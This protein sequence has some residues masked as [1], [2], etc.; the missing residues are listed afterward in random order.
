LRRF[1]AEFVGLPEDHP[2]VARACI[3]IMAPF[4]MLILSDSR[5]IKR[6]L[7]SLGLGADDAADMAR[8]LV[9]FAIGGLEAIGRDA[10]R[11]HS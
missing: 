2:S 1:V 10:R 4:C 3:S 6:A 7:P 9:Q 11:R 8:H 5:R